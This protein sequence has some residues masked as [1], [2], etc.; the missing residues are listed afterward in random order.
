MKVDM[1]LNKETKPNQTK[2]PQSWLKSLENFILSSL[3]RCSNWSFSV[4]WMPLDNCMC[5]PIVTCVTI[6][7]RLTPSYL[8]FLNHSWPSD[9]LVVSLISG[10]GYFTFLY[11]HTKHNRE[12][13]RKEN[14]QTRT[15]VNS[16]CKKGEVSDTV[17]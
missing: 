16:K 2:P 6:H 7:H 11:R 12:G 5:P 4:S 1:P 15:W 10:Q 8:N 9:R 17:A 13:G 3:C 14:K